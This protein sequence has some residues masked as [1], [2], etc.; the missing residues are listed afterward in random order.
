MRYMKEMPRRF[1]H[2]FREGE[3]G[4]GCRALLPQRVQMP[5]NAA[6]DLAL[7]DTLSN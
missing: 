4:T 1:K 6:S 3:C 7:V 5:S 2:G